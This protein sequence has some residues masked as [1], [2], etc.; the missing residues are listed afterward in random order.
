MKRGCIRFGLVERQLQSGEVESLDLQ[1]GVNVIVGEPN[2]GKTM[3]LRM[4]DFL[5]GSTDKPAEALSDD[6]A[7]KYDSITAEVLLD[8]VTFR[9]ERRW[10]EKGRQGTIFIDEQPM[11]APEAQ[12]FILEKLSIP[13]L[14]YPRGNPYSGQTWPELSFREILRHIYR[15]QD[16]WTDLA[17]KQAKS[18]QHAS[19]MQFL[20]LAEHIF[21]EEYGELVNTQQKRT[22]L[23]AR[24]DQF[25]ETLNSVARELL[26][27]NETMVAVTPDAI[28]TAIEAVGEHLNKL[29]TSRETAIRH[30]IDGTAGGALTKKIERLAERRAEL[31]SRRE[32]LALQV[33]KNAR[34]H[35]DLETYR[36]DLAAEQRKLARAATAESIMADL[37]ITHCPAC[38]QTVSAKRDHEGKCFLCEQQITA[39]NIETARAR[40][41]FE[42]V[43]V[44]SEVKEAKELQ[45]AAKKLNDESRRALREVKGELADIEAT[46]APARQKLAGLVQS[47]PDSISIE[48]GRAQGRLEQ[49]DRV[50]AVHEQNLQLAKDIAALD[51]RIKELETVV[52]KAGK[53]LDFDRAE[54]VLAGG[55][56]DYLT[57]IERERPDTWK[58]KEIGAAISRGS[59]SIRVGPRRWKRALGGTNTLY[60]LMAYHF[61]LLRLSREAWCHYPGLVIVDLPPS[62][63]GVAVRDKENFI[64]KPFLDLTKKFDGS[65]QV[66]FTG[67]SFEGLERP[68]RIEF[69]EQYV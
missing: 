17:D 26:P 7:D 40:L 61:S 19:L 59:S 11:T 8:D 28:R 20:G 31:Q 21:T 62:L 68:H 3:W 43:Q 10:K 49:L 4:L 14:H 6:L 65:V 58:Q 27:P 25:Q 30:V 69:T 24:A 12:A 32:E 1:P 23:A 9:F 39:P 22:R 60:F 15:R 50:K 37:R 34:R 35:D 53:A 16:C 18:T 52:R 67:A 44:A 38:D 42:R 45:A 48:I 36:K 56:N 51:K 33:Q 55:F 13:S 64:V 46:L 41:K 54:Q 47:E 63:E 5:L 57:A 29:S 2:T 66:I